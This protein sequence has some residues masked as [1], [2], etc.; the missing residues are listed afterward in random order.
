MQMSLVPFRVFI[1]SMSIIHWFGA[2]WRSAQFIN[3]INN[4]TLIRHETCTQLLS[5]SKTCTALFNAV[6]IL[7]EAMNSE[8]CLLFIT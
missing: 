7:F 1:P 5:L 3:I 4:R 2:F 8:L 6:K